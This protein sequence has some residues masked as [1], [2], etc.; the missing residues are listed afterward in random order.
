MSIEGILNKIQAETDEKIA[1]IKAETDSEIQTIEAELK[2]FEKAVLAKSEEK[3]EIEAKRAYEQAISRAETK[4]R[5]ETLAVKQE[6]VQKAFKNGFEAILNLPPEKLRERYATML[7]SFGEKEGEILYGKEDSAVFNG[8]FD[9][10]VQKKIN[11]AKFAKTKSDNFDHGFML[12]AGRIQ[13][14][15]RAGSVFSQIADDFTDDVSLMLFGGG[16]K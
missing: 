6:L 11:G 10:I 9:S 16:D 7:E 15:A 3:A 1:E 4:F 5:M 12:I 2:N 14:D 13:F 8:E